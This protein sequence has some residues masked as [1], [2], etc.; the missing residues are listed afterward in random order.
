MPFKIKAFF[1]GII[2][3]LA[4]VCPRF[5][6]AEITITAIDVG[7]GDAVLIQHESYNVLIDGGPLQNTVADYLKNKGISHIDLLIATHA[8]ADHINGLVGVLNQN[9]VAKVLYNGQTH[10]T[11]TFERFVEAIIASGAKYHEPSRGESFSF[12]TM[13]I[14]ILHPEGSAMDYN[15]N[16]HDKSIVIRIVYGDFAAIISGDIEKNGE[17]EILNSNINVS[18]QVLEL[19]HHG[20]K[21]SS[22]PYW[23]QTVNPKLAF[24]QAGKDN[25]YGFPHDETIITLNKLNIPHMGTAT[26]GNITIKANK[27]GSFY[28]NGKF[29]QDNKKETSLPGVLMLLLEE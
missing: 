19:G 15:G 26:H 2:L 24:W 12:G 1:I 8:H 9:S 5:L 17:F 7:Q 3:W 18:A 23:I 4:V 14:W 6:F 21:T 13:K 25:E 29:F 28:A 11:L 16:L 22:D 27:D 20:S 10:T